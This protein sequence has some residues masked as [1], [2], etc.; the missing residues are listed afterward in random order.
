MIASN[1]GSLRLRLRLVAAAFLF[2]LPAVLSHAQALEPPTLLGP[3][4]SPPPS[5]EWG[6]TSF[7]DA[8]FTGMSNG[9]IGCGNVSN[10]STTS[11]GS[12]YC[13]VDTSW[14]RVRA[15]IT[16]DILQMGTGSSTV[17]F[18][19]TDSWL[20]T[21]G[22]SGDHADAIQSWVLSDF[23]LS[24]IRTTFWLDSQGS[25][26][27]VGTGVRN[28]DLGRIHYLKMDHVYIRG[29]QGIRSYTPDGTPFSG[30]HVWIDSVCLDNSDIQIGAWNGG[31]ITVDHF[32]NVY[33]GC[34][35]SNGR[36]VTGTPL[37][38]SDVIY[39]KS[40]GAAGPGTVVG[41]PN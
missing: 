10:R 31:R 32:A 34:S 22:L 12:S 15:N 35:I 37:K 1:K 30:M 23:T 25:G 14:N 3:A 6:P 33:S 29:G 38:C 21:Y 4:G 11:R 28:G 5:T 8:R 39:P 7:N 16:D 41:C 2:L 17:D 20:Q 13:S 27:L 18:T 19:I 40:G 36:V 9:S 24:L 26:S